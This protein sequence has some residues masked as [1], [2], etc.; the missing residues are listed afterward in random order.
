MS[1]RIESTQ[2]LRGEAGSAGSPGDEGA[3]GGGGRFRIDGGLRLILRLLLHDFDGRI[4][5]RRDVR[6]DVSGTGKDRTAAVR[7]GH[8]I[9][10]RSDL[11]EH[12]HGA[13]E[14]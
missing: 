11:R 9:R 2:G 14:R 13:K 8:A 3:R 4:V 6:A 5:G 12:R 1:G 7:C 10:A